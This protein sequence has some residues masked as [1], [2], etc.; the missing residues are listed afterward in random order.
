MKRKMLT[1]AESIKYE[2]DLHRTRL[3]QSEYLTDWFLQ[4][5]SYNGTEQ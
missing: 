2:G 5:R 4:V 3:N 1:L